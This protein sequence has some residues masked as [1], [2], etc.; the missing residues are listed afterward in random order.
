[1]SSV[2]SPPLKAIAADDPHADDDALKMPSGFNVML[3]QDGRVV[4]ERSYDEMPAPAAAAAPLEPALPHHTQNAVP[5]LHSPSRPANAPARQLRWS[6]LGGALAATLSIFV[7]YQ[8]H[9]RWSEAAKAPWPDLAV[10]AEAVQRPEVAAAVTPAAPVPSAAVAIA[11]PQQAPA[12]LKAEQAEAVL[13]ADP[14]AAAA[15]PR[16]KAPQPALPR[17]PLPYTAPA[18]SPTPAPRPVQGP[19]TAAVAALGL[20]TPV[21]QG[22]P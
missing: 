5:A 18:A 3:G 13:A 12:P 15:V 16:P 11:P 8:L 21:Q 17:Q 14:P 7:G 19:C 20:C 6:F 2:Q 10:G 1:M 9:D 22:A 4:I